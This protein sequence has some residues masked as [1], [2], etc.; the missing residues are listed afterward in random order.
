MRR[1]CA[2]DASTLN[3]LYPLH[4]AVFARC[5]LLASFRILSP[6]LLLRRVDDV[7]SRQHNLPPSSDFMPWLSYWGI[8][9][10]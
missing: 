5:P 1:K 3:H 2:P 4:P 6:R 7:Q 8:T 9:K 10:C